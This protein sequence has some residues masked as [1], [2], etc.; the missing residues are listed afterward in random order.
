VEGAAQLPHGSSDATSNYRSLCVLATGGMGRVELAMRQEGAFRRLYAVKRLK[1]S[2]REEEDFLRMFLDEAR[3]AGFLRHPNVVSVLD[4][5]RDADGPYLVMDYVEGVSLNSL[6]ARVR[7][8]PIPTQVALSIALQIA[9]GLH[10]A[11]ELTSPEGEPLHLVHRDVSP[12][13]VLVG[14]DGVARIT[15]FGIA[16]AMGRMTKTTTGV[17]KG[18]YGYM[19]PELLQFEEPDRR[20]DLFSLGVVLYELLAGE[21]LYPNVDGMDGVRRIL[22]EPPPD[23]AEVRDDIPPEIVQLLFALLAKDKDHR[24]KTARE[25]S[26]KIEPLLARVVADEGKIEVGDYLA[27]LFA[28]RRAEEKQRIAAALSS[29]APAAKAI[30]PIAPTEIATNSDIARMTRPRRTGLWLGVASLLVGA[31]AIGWAVTTW[32]TSRG[33]PEPAADV[34]VASVPPSLPELADE[35]PPEPALAEDEPEPSSDAPAMEDREGRPAV[36][37][38]RPR[39]NM[40][41]RETAPMGNPSW[42]WQ[43]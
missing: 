25:V 14:Y 38:G 2:Y 37:N 20:A 15:D 41:V 27:T 31:L 3:I 40:R 35:P 18:K 16:K 4:M 39:A 22:K 12:Q 34:P 7:S 23:I 21:R 28:E 19:A 36:R 33:V 17:L 30:P 42:G 6:I 1:E 32:I 10:A 11:H 43:P 13:N 26:R 9:E 24:P 5:G 8:S 29:A